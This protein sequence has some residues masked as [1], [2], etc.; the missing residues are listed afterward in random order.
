[1]TIRIAAADHPSLHGEIAAF[2]DR[3]GAEQRW[4]GPTAKRNPKP[5]RSLLD[6]LLGRGGFRVAATDGDRIVGLARVDGAGELFLAVDVEHRGLGIGTAL[7][8]AAAERARDLFYSR[9]VIRSS[10][11]S[12]AVR[13]VGEG[14][15]CLVVDG[16][17][18]RIELIL[19]L[20]AGERT[21]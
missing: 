15:G 12:R 14:L 20:A 11:R 4:F 13:R 17:Q 8:R 5:T 7:G 6:A 18:G 21:A 1:M 2:V 16:R 9:L 3:L 10:R 19:D